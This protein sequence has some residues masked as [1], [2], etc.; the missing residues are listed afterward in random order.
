MVTT[1]AQP[2]GPPSSSGHDLALVVVEVDGV[3]CGLPAIDVVELHPV[4]RITPLPRAPH[5]VE[6]V[7]NVRGSLVTVINLRARLGLRQRPPLV[8]DHLVMVRVGARTVALRVDRAVEMVTVDSVRI[9]SALGVDGACH[10]SAVAK[11][12]DGLLVIHDVETFLSADEAVALEVAVAEAETAANASP[13][14]LP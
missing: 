9:E 4:V 6:G 8:G 13:E 11:L 1:S 12:D 2:S 3:R 10:V 5:V 7:I 14:Q